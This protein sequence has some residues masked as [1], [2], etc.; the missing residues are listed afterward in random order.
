MIIKCLQRKKEKP[1][2]VKELLHRNIAGW[3]PAR[4]PDIIH[5]SDLLKPEEYCPREY[6]FLRAGYVKGKDQFVGTS[7]RT[8]FDHG[9][10]MESQ[11]RNSYLRKEA[12]GNWYC[13]VCKQDHHVFGHDPVLPCTNCGKTSWLYKETRFTDPVSGVSGSFDVILD[14]GQKKLR[15]IEIKIMAPD[16]FKK[17]K[18]PLAEHRFRT[19]LYLQLVKKSTAHESTL[20]NSSE[21]TIIYVSRT[22][23]FKDTSLKEAGIMDA[24]FSPFK[25]FNVVRSD[26]GAETQLNKAEVLTT[27]STLGPKRG[28]Y[29]PCGICS[30]GMN[31]RAQ[32]CAAIK[33]CFSGKYPGGLTWMEKGK[34]KHEG[35]A[36][37]VSE[38][39]KGDL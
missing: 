1:V 36:I 29:I 22:F 18:A 10:Y 6:A 28:K 12:V 27:W 19:S 14:I 33:P 3:E 39:L 26:G 25:E 35:D 2:S 30:G 38:L 8:T 37:L 24:P 20:I 32:N 5:A 23:G 11:I 15:L 16:D 9:K 31:K 34:R 4:D 7:L 21:A 13:G 17:L